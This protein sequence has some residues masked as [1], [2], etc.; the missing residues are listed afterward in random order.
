MTHYSIQEL[1]LE[2][3]PREKL[4]RFGA[5]SMSTAELI[6][7]IL[8]S[9][10]KTN[11]V[12]QLAQEISKGFNSIQELSEA[13]ISELC[14]VKGVGLVKAIQ[15]K[16]AFSLGTRACRQIIKPRY[17]I[18][19]P[20]HAYHFIKDELER[21][22]REIF[23][24]ILLDTKGFVIT[25]EIV[26]IGSL[27]ST[28]VHPREVFYPGIRH[29]ASSM[30]LVHNHPSGDPTPSKQDYEITQVLIEVGELVKIPI[31]DHLIIGAQTYLSLRQQGFSFFPDEEKDAKRAIRRTWAKRIA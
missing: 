3:R 30:I 2:E 23:I 12:M 5:E 4:V 8:G 7:I 21:E 1:P 10:T 6:A 26:S 13:T 28:L 17:R 16:A 24:V 25:K 15:L 31:Y 18:E 20:V 14:A 11:P 9:G 22:T 19:H 27:A 29:K